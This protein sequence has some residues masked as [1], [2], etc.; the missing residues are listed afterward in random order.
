MVQN[1]SRISEEEN[2]NYWNFLTP[3][4]F[5]EECFIIW[6]NFQHARKNIQKNLFLSKNITFKTARPVYK[7]FDTNIKRFQANHL[8]IS[9]KSPK[10]QYQKYTFSIE[11]KNFCFTVCESFL[12][13]FHVKSFAYRSNCLT[14]SKYWTNK[15]NTLG[16]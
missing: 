12:I 7:K 6:L 9:I 2:N 11:I 4:V 8:T 14:L 10:L 16:R 13:T 3:G 15:S 5:D 1:G